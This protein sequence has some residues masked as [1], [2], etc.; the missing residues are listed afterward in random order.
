[1][2]LETIG[3]LLHQCSKTK[4]F[5]LH[6]AV[7]KKGLQSHVFISNQVLNMYAKCGQVFLAR[8]VFDEMIQ[9]NIVSWSAMIS[10]YDQCGEHWMALKLFS[11]MQLLPNEFTF[12]SALSASASLVA[13]KQGQQIHAQSLKSGYSSVSFVSNSLITM[14][15][16]CGHCSDALSVY[17]NSAGLNSVSY[18]ALISGF[19][20]N[21]EPEE[22]FEV[23]KLML[24][25]GFVPNRFSFAGLLGYCTK[26]DDLRRGMS[27]HCKA[28]K[29]ELDST[30]LIGNLMMTMY[31]KSNFVE[32]VEKAFRLIKE[33]DVISW[34]TL[35]SAFS[36]FDDQAK[37]LRFFKEMMNECSI[38]PDDFTFASIISSC[39]W[40]AS[41]RHGKQ[42]HGYLFRTRLCWD[43]GVNNALVNMYAK[44]GSIGH[45]H[46]VFNRMSYH[47][48]VSWNTMIAAF[49]NHGLGERAIET[50]EQM[51]KRRVKPD[52]FTFIGLLIACNHSGLVRKG[53]LYFNSMEEAYG[54]TAN[55]EHFSCLIDMLGRA[56]RLSE[57]EEYMKK[58]PHWNNP[59]VFG[60]L[61]SACWLHGNVIIG[62]S[63][64][65]QLLEVQP[66]TTTSPFVLLSNL[67][68]SGGMWNDVTNARKKLKGS[69][70]RKGPGY[71]LIE[72]KGKHDKFTIGDFS[73]L[74]IEEIKNVLGTLNWS[75][76]TIFSDDIT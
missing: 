48:L 69:G 60:S 22:G 76:D 30:P 17:S 56:G 9:R 12:A 37:C 68:A 47:N 16:K 28:I 3:T 54:V 1:M 70:L 39:A 53:E 4:A 21:H 10:G 58:F 24:Q 18:N 55:I 2:I 64:A 49:G 65:K 23:F 6:T 73:H 8:R 41:I 52:S 13:L 11:Q 20:E 35:I 51:K 36:Q 27:L 34:N 75:I 71:S 45:A 32:E 74:R 63:L 5:C 15:M 33:K 62:E 31:S 19:I 42:V 50:F 61:L 44:C 40:H 67:Y 14:Y 38:K 46:N 72:V 57:A 7:L 26:S 66:V 59:V 29:L 25:Q 43:V